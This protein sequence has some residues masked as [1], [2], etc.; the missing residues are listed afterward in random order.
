VS[1]RIS[2]SYVAKLL[3]GDMNRSLS[4]LLD[5]QRMAA[6]L[7]RVN[8]YADDPRAVASIARLNDLLAAN[9]G[10]VQNVGRSRALV[11]GTDAAFQELSAILSELEVIALRESSATANDSTMT[12]SAEEVD[13]L[14]GRMLEVLNASVEGQY[15][16]AGRR[17]DQAPFVEVGGQVV[18]R[19]DDGDIQAA[20]GPHSSIVVN[21]SGE[22]FAGPAGYFRV[23]EDVAAALRAGDQATVLAAVDRIG[24]LEE[25]LGR[26]IIGVGGRQNDLDW[27]AETLAA[28]DE[29]LRTSLSGEQDADVARLATDLSRTEA[30][31]Q[32]S[33]MV[34]SKLFQYNL[35]DFLR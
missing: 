19:G 9:D 35:M 6:T 14:L 21:V 7:R 5:Q 16:F 17:T 33:L 30:A 15:L 18:Y 10:Y 22:G 20:T 29:R 27:A 8:S 28:R 34:T 13:G 31:Y 2:D 11:D 4:Q 32:A 23:L 24:V 25:D 12:V 1:I 3:T 26:R